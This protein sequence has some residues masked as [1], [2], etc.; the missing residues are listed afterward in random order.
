[1]KHNIQ[2]IWDYTQ[3][4]SRIWNGQAKWS[5]DTFGPAE[6]IGPFGPAKHLCLE[7]EEIRKSP[8]DPLEYADAFILVIETAWRAGFSESLF[9]T[10]VTNMVASSGELGIVSPDVAGSPESLDTAIQSADRARAFAYTAGVEGNSRVLVFYLACIL[11]CVVAAAAENGI[12]GAALLSAVQ[13][14]R[15]INAARKWG[16]DIRDGEPVFHKRGSA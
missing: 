10:H 2:P 15:A 5:E 1:M 13:K 9:F 3:D 4:L 11:L 6:K 8:K 16:T 7:L 12:S 14:K